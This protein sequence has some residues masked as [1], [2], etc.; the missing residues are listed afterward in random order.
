MM[1]VGTCRV[2]MAKSPFWHDWGAGK[3]SLRHPIHHFG[4]CSG[5]FMTL[6]SR[7]MIL[8]VKA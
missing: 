4:L 5:T 3:P 8:K 6:K 7:S 1:F 2:S